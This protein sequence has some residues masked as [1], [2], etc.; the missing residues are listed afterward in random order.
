ML[1]TLAHTS[2]VTMPTVRIRLR[3]LMAEKSAR[4]ERWDDPITQEELAKAI[5]VANG[6]MSSWVRGTVERL[7]KETIAKLCKYFECRIE[8]LLQLELDDQPPA[9]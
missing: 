6:T 5:G 9:Q 1:R 4:D 2:V 3:Q 8:D 7:D